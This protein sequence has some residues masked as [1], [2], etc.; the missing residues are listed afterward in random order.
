MVCV[1]PGLTTLRL[2]HSPPG[3]LRTSPSHCLRP[4]APEFKNVTGDSWCPT[5]SGPQ[6]LTF[7]TDGKRWWERSCWS[8]PALHLPTLTYRNQLSL[9]CNTREPRK[10]ELGF[11]RRNSHIRLRPISRPHLL[12]TVMCSFIY[13]NWLTSDCQLP[14]WP[15]YQHRWCLPRCEGIS[16]PCQHSILEKMSHNITRK[17]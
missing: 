2:P 11:I 10:Q 17:T 12:N 5:G 9:K 16:F 14:A 13:K 1:A 7:I 8:E 15:F 4:A 3:S 6:G